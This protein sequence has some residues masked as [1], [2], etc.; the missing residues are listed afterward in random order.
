[1]ALATENCSRLKII[2]F[3]MHDFNQGFT[4]INELIESCRPNIFLS[5]EHWLT[6]DNLCKFDIFSN[7]FTFDCSAM[8]NCVDSE[9]LV[10][11]PFGGVITM[12]SNSLRN[13]T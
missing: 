10:G 11:Q 8:N 4:A 9:M 7:Y 12:L 5:Q 13:L 2:S 6:P 3:N 1:M